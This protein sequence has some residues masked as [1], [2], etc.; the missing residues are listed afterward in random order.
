MITGISG[1]TRFNH[2]LHEGMVMKHIM[3][4]DDCQDM[5]RLV[6]EIL[7]ICGYECSTATSG[8]ECLEQLKSFVPDLILLD[9]MM[10][11]MDGWATLAK[12]KRAGLTKRTKVAFLSIK[13]LSEE[14]RKRNLFQ[15]IVRYI[16]KPFSVGVFV[17]EIENIFLEAS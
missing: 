2:Y 14:D 11:G 13:T 3:I 17:K 1:S 4:V 12:L 9:I 5:A 15:D 8:R 10:P 7:H 6:E 16:T